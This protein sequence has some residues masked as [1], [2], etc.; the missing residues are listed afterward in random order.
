[1]LSGIKDY[2]SISQLII[3][4]KDYIYSS[5]FYIAGLLLGTLLFK[6][7][8]NSALTKL[9]ELIFKNTETNFASVFLNRFFLYFSIY[10]VCVLLGMCLIGFP[11][12]NAVPLIIGSELA[13]KITYFYVNYKFKGLG[14]SLLMIIPEGAAVTT[15]LIHAIKTSKNLSKNIYDISSNKTQNAIDI[16][17]YLRKYVLYSLIITL[18][19]LIN[20]LASFLIGSIIKI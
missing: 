1:M 8:N 18:I 15:V 4:E 6:T 5:L 12:L 14:F 2:K 20:A 3:E 16:K 13:I 11:L 10:A 17:E 19:S 9:I 7:I